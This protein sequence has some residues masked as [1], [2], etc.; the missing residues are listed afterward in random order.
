MNHEELAN[1][2]QTGSRAEPLESWVPRVGAILLT[3]T[4]RAPQLITEDPEKMLGF[5]REVTAKM[6]VEVLVAATAGLM[7]IDNMLN[8]PGITPELIS[9][10]QDAMK[11]A[12]KPEGQ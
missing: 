11:D 6:P 5:L 12:D 4:M 1:A 3:I 10:I 7:Q 8:T 9:E 2:L